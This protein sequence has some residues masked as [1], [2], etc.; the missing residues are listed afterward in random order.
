MREIKTQVF[1]GDCKDILKDFE[2]ECVD[3]IFTPPHTQI[4]ENKLMVVLSPKNMLKG[5]NRDQKVVLGK[6]FR[7]D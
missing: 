3:L 5:S 1:L 6:T 7:T 4:G 2:N